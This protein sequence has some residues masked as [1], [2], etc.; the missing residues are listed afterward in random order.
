ME[1]KYMRFGEFVKRSGRGV[2]TVRGWD[3]SG[4]LVAKRSMGGQRYYE[5]EDVFKAFKLRLENGR[6]VKHAKK[7]VIYYRI[8]PEADV[9]DLHTKVAEVKKFCS[10]EGIPVDE[11][12]HDVGSGLNFT[13]PEFL[14]LMRRVEMLE[15]SRIVIADKRTFA[16]FGHDYFVTF[17]RDHGCEV[18]VANTE[19]ASAQDRTVN[20]MIIDEMLGIL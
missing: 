10:A 17:A 9:S 1:K 19:K 16:Q 4:R 20:E 14:T 2:C 3:R 18:V 5:E 12:I 11:V 7:S 13:R 8:H 15:F 6:T